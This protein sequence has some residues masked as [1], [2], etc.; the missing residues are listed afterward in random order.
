MADKIKAIELRICGERT[1]LLLVLTDKILNL[2]R[3]G[4]SVLFSGCLTALILLGGMGNDAA[5]PLAIFS[6][7]VL[8]LFLVL[9]G[10]AVVI[11]PKLRRQI[12]SEAGKNG[13]AVFEGTSFTVELSG[14]AARQMPYSAIRGQYWVGDDY[15]LYIDSDGYKTLLCFAID[16]ESFDLIYM[17][18]GTLTQHKV[19]F[20]R[21]KVKGN[22]A[23]K[24]G[25]K[26]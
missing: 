10:Y 9:L 20:V 25:T 17:L 22:T 7:L 2:A 16:E 12:L 21:I 18:A 6:G 26:E 23:I 5:A 14:E 24:K 19:K 3:I 8:L 4:M 13:R 1:R 11:R 15:I